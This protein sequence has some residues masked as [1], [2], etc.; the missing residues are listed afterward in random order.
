MPGYKTRN[1]DVN[2]GKLTLQLRALKDHMQFSDPDGLADTAGICSASWS[3]FG[4]LWQA[5]QPQPAA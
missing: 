4:Q 3:I 2:V 1:I 5:S